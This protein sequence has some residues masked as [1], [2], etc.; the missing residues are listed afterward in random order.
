MHFL[1]DTDPV[2]LH[3]DAS[4]YGIGGYLFQVFAGTEHPIA[5]VSKSLSLSQ[6]RWAV[7]QKEAYA[8]FF[9]CMHLKSLLR[10]RK[11]TLR[12]DRRNLLYITENSNPMIVRWYMALSEYSFNFEF[13]SGVTNEV[14]DSMSQLCRN[15]MKDAPREFSK[16]VI[17]SAK[18]IEKF[19]LAKAQYRT[20]SSLHN[21]NVGHFGL[22]RTLKRLKA[23][24]QVWEFQRQRVRHFIDHCPCCQKMSLLKIPI[25]AHGFT[26]ST[27]TPMEC[28]N[29]DF[30]AP[31]P[32]D[33]YVFVRYV[34][35]LG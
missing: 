2:F 19:T 8:L 29:I 12:T 6:I 7:I 4:D 5:F 22:D 23:I 20:I 35:S 33:G 3:T 31:F 17:F 28:L 11:F 25:H 30:V 24:G 34:H 18:I 10:D 15:N 26:I 32:D 1:N 9:V 27:Y 21:S 14:A 16:E 13:I